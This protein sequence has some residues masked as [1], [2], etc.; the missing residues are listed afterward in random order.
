MQHLLFLAH[1][2]P[3]PP[4]K[5]D[6]LR[7]FHLLRYLGERYQV[8]LGSFVDD[9]EDWRYVEEV[10]KLC[11]S[12][13]FAKL[14]PLRAKLRSLTGL[15]SGHALSIPY[16]RDSGLQ[17]WVD[18]ELAMRPIKH[19][20]V[21]SSVM[22]QY[23][24][25]RAGVR[26]IADLVD[27]D[28]DKWAQYAQ[29][30][31]WPWSALY[32]REGRRLLSHEREIASAFDATTFVSQSEAQMF[33]ALAP[34]CAHKIG[35]FNNGV[36]C[37][38]F[39]PQHYYPDPYANAE[40]VIVFTG[41]MDYW[42]NVDAVSWFARNIFPA[43]RRKTSMTRFYIAGANPTR[44]VVKLCAIPGVVVT[45]KVSDIRPYLAH[46]KVA[47]APMRIARGVQNKI[48]EAMAMEKPV[49]ASVEA[50]GAVQAAAGEELLVAKDRNEWIALVA[51]ALAGEVD[52]LGSKARTRIV[53]DYNWEKSLSRIDGLLKGL[54][55]LSG[56]P[57]PARRYGS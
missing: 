8:H 13:H 55:V 6:K 41:A 1:R 7:S 10:R 21:F 30:K 14:H 36:D 53:A 57:A 49:V 16:Y 29:S 54:R 15:F 18:G 23:V 32:R 45:G 44:A 34:E 25:G 46:A 4:N 19:I 35:H 52:A 11:V 5:G 12:T 28:S 48:L 51:A 22:A 9:E 24:R 50:A 2:I 31:S 56:S 47:V 39:S 26:R 43:V 33:R 17:E 42:P 40:R 20:L 37:N 3:Y 27:I 38:Y